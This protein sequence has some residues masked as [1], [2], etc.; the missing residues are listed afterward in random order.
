MGQFNMMSER[1][2][3]SSS[4][5]RSLLAGGIKRPFNRLGQAIQK[6]DS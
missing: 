2:Q 1:L 6:S 3:Q 4:I 5:F